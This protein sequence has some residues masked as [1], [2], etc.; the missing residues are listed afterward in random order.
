MQ[1]R[2]IKPDFAQNFRLVSAAK[3]GQHVVTRGLVIGFFEQRHFFLANFRPQQRFDEMLRAKIFDGLV[4]CMIQGNGSHEEFILRRNG[5]FEIA[6]VAGHV[7]HGGPHNG[8][9]TNH[10]D[11]V[12]ARGQQEGFY[13]VI[14]VDDPGIGRPGRGLQLDGGVQGLQIVS[15]G[16][17]M[18]EHLLARRFQSNRARRSGHLSSLGDTPAATAAAR[19]GGQ[20]QANHTYAHA[21]HRENDR[22]GPT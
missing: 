3:N 19:D 13:F 2:A 21:I 6:A 10:T 1:V 12:R 18:I 16:I 9:L 8:N 20:C 5:D 15:E 22:P 4:T 7:E 14:L 11:I 17:V